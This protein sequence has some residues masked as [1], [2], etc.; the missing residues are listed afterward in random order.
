MHTNNGR[1]GGGAGAGHRARLFVF[2]ALLWVHGT[3]AAHEPSVDVDQASTGCR[4]NGRFEAPVP[5]SVAWEVLTDYDHIPRFVRS[6]KL[7]HV[8]KRDSSGVLVRQDAV[9]GFLFFH[10]HVQ[11]LLDVK[12]DRGARIGFRDISGKDFTTYFG[13]WRL[14]AD[15]TGTRVRYQLEAEPRM[16]LP[17]SMCRG[18][19]KGVARDLLE[20]VRAEMIRR[21]GANGSP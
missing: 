10:R 19:L 20:Q 4:V 21:A 16:A 9:S 11:V 5:A 2:A 12:E 8:E 6:M 3:A 15:S 7:S 13:E 14:E 1:S 18:M 17:R